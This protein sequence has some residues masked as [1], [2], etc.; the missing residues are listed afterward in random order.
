MLTDAVLSPDPLLDGHVCD[1][2]GM[3]S[4]GCPADAIPE[5]RTVEL[6]IGDRVFS[7]AP[8]DTGKCLHYHQGWD[9]EY[10][11]FVQE[12]SS[13]ENLPPY[14]RFLRHRFRHHSICGARGCVRAC[15]D[16]LEKAGRIEKQ[17]HTPMIE[18]KQ[19]V[20]GGPSG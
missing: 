3:C 17:Y 11:P 14:F 10:S 15:M 2:C 1:D 18:G 12:D 9:P 20:M 8:L 5:Q 7:H 4:E 6:R 19:W 13:E 16:H